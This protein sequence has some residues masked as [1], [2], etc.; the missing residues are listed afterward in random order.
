MI[1]TP[2]LMA[3]R[4][5]ERFV[6]DATLTGKVDE[7]HGEHVTFAEQ[8]EYVDEDTKTNIEMLWRLG[9]A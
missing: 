2:M 4:A 6:D 9:Y 7:L 8:P 3:V 1:L 5:V